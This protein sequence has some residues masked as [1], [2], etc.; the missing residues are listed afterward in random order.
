MK[1]E[2]FSTNKSNEN[3]LEKQILSEFTP[4]QQK[5]IKEKQSIL[6]AICGF[7][8]K[9]FSMPVYL[10]NPGSGW[11]W[12]F[13][14]NHVKIDPTD[15]LEKPMD[16]L[17]FVIA[18]EGGHRR[19]TRTEFI[20]DDVLR[21][22]GFLT[23]M[24]CIEDPRMNNFVAE[25]YPVFR[26]QMVFSYELDKI[27]HEKMLSLSSEKLGFIPRHELAGLTY[28]QQWFREVNGQDFQ[29]DE[30]LPDDVKHVVEQTLS[31]AAHSWKVYPT[32]AEADGR[33]SYN[34]NGRNITGEE[35]I[36]EFAKKSYEINFEKVWPIY[37]T[38]LQSDQKDAEISQ[39]LE[40][41]KKELQEKLDSQDQ[42]AENS[43][44]GGE[45]GGEQGGGS[46]KLNELMKN[47]SESE[48]QQLVDE[49][50]KSIEQ[51]NQSESGN[52]RAIPLENLPQSLQEKIR[53]M[54][55][56]LS[57]EIKKDLEKRAE[58]KLK[59]VSK[60]FAEQLQS[61][62]ETE[63]QHELGTDEQSSESGKSEQE[64]KQG[65]KKD[66]D[67]QEYPESEIS[68]TRDNGDKK[69]DS[70][71]LSYEE[72][73]SIEHDK[74]S[75]QRTL[76][77][78]INN[79]ENR[80]E[81]TMR[82]VLP[83]INS[84]EDDLRDVFVQRRSRG[85]QTGQ[86]S[87]RKIDIARRIQEKAKG[88]NVFESTAWKTREAPTEQD[89]AISILVDLSG[90]MNDGVKINETFKS[91]VVLSEVLNKLSL[92]VEILGFNDRIH[93]YQQY[94]DDINDDMRHNMSDM[95]DEVDSNK[96]KGKPRYNDD[97][98][99]ILQT[100]ERLAKQDVKQKFLIV[101]SDGL[102]EESSEHSGSQYKLDRVIP[103]VTDETDQKIIG[104]GIGLGT[105]HVSKYYPN[106]IA[107]IDTKQM[108][109]KISDLL[110]D[111]I[112]NYNQY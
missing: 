12:N 50:Q 47:L 64:G 41:L 102:P 6:S 35:A 28:I 99:A 43:S 23:M 97:G 5:I 38:L 10:N 24:N 61:H 106:S 69:S 77:N 4:D 88:I 27:E 3:N 25:S 39:M 84:L 8:G 107:N 17:R 33:E 91:V 52:D 26:D 9:D 73:Q 110:R 14:D 89:Y 79:P 22:P 93:I 92:N 19:V 65:N 68:E 18:H 1:F 11:Y 13:K 100:S 20:P 37:K 112:I 78:L 85:W 60:E 109:T 42:K 67:S 44:Q 105:G 74:K 70:N 96:A 30:R 98:W 31:D 104:L 49:L 58:Q 46:G 75:I 80:Y 59:E 34:Y 51:G 45:Q 86:T 54:I 101:L 55:D 108:A 53:E 103:H 90:S 66:Q 81:Q 48:Q 76:D 95:L 94:G 71:K 62:M 29:I 32:K 63:K 2:S 87:G 56:N 16:Y 111:I 83:I 21:A 72:L 82:E 40:D 15:L 36:Y 57:P 7:I